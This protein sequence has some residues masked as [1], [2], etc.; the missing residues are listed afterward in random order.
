MNEISFLKLR[1]KLSESE[2]VIFDYC[3]QHRKDLDAFTIQ[4]LSK[5]LFVSPASISRMAQRLGFSGYKEFKYT[6]LFLNTKE[7]P[8]SDSFTS[9]VKDYQ[10]LIQENL[11]GSLSQLNDERINKFQEL[12]LKAQ[13][14]EVFA[15]G[16]S[17]VNGQDFSR[18]LQSLNLN[19]FARKDWDELVRVSQNLKNKDLAVF[20]SQSGQTKLILDCAKNLNK[21]NVSIISF[22]ANKDATLLSLSKLGFVCPCIYHYKNDADLSSRIMFNLVSDLLIWKLAENIS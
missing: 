13:N 17:C 11:S 2:K 14:I 16:G 10:L 19:I 5:K 15:V 9:L 21:N 3:I 20:F 7:I 22:V 8:I 1:N 6:L 12:I 4:C 18:K